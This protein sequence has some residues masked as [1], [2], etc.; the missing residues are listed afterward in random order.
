MCLKWPDGGATTSYGHSNTGMHRRFWILVRVLDCILHALACSAT[1]V[2]IQI[3][4]WLLSH[5]V[6]STALLGDDGC[7]VY[8]KVNEF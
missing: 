7:R 2:Y 8:S 1:G 3:E 4:S 5:T 6:G